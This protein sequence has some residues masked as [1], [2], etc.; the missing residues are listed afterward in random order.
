[1]KTLGNRKSFGANTISSEKARFTRFVIVAQ[2]GLQKRLL[3]TA[4][5]AT[6]S[7]S[8]GPLLLM[9]EIAPH[10]KEE[11]RGESHKLAEEDVL[12]EKLP[13]NSVQ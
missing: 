2:T 5:E 10:W 4:S 7:V 6:A 12:F 9:S 8:R 1:M 3:R 13:A 11:Q